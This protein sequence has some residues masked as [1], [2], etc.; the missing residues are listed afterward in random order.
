MTSVSK[1]SGIL[2]P[3][4]D[5][6][7]WIA[8]NEDQLQPPVNNYCL[9]NEDFVVMC[10]GGPNE[11]T[12]YHINETPEWFY[13]HRG[14]MLL[15]VVEAADT[16]NPRFRDIPIREGEMFLLPGNTPHNPVRFA[17]TVGLVLEQRRPENSTDRLRWYC[18]ACSHIVHEDQF[19]CTD[20]GSQLK[21]LIEAF[22]G[23]PKLRTC[24]AC[25][26]VNEAK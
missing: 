23:D 5:F 9:Y 18:S 1:T 20:L 2:P 19:H 15:K 3:P 11:R 21:P 26:V 25:G 12:D 6:R 14:D 13:Q 24:P 22:R 8:E 17:N 7:R 10:V 4:I 16:E